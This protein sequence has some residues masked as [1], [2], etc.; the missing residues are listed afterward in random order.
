MIILSIHVYYEYKPFIEVL[1]NEESLYS[2]TAG[3][4]VGLFVSYYAVSKIRRYQLKN[5]EFLKELYD[6]LC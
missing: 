4:I 5:L 3:F 6:R 2:L 1:K